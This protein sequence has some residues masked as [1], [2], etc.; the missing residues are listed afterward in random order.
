MMKTSKTTP[1]LK[2]TSPMNSAGVPWDPRR[3]EIL[4]YQAMAARIARR[5]KKLLAAAKGGK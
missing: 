4:S 3:W 1:R 5:A 2:L